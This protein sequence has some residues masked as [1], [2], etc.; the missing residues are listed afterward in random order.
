MTPR[1]YFTLVLRAIGV[2]KIA[3]GFQDL[4][5]AWNIHEK[6]YTTPYDTTGGFMS[7]GFTQVFVGGVLLF[8]AAAISALLV[9]ASKAPQEPAIDSHDANV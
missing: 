8:G 2:W 6:F 4:T 9:P 1:M 7:L 3:Y 5:T